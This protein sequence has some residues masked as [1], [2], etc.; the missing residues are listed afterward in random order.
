MGFYSMVLDSLVRV[1]EWDFKVGFFCF[2]KDVVAKKGFYQAKG[3]TKERLSEAT[4]RTF[5]RCLKETAFCD[6]G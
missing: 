1:F 2:D 3:F 5:F 6:S 4:G